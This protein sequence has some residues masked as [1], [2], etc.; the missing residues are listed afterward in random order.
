MKPNSAAA[1]RE[2]IATVQK[3]TLEIP[4]LE[5]T[6]ADNLKSLSTLEADGYL[7][8]KVVIDEIVRRQAFAALF[9]R[10]IEA[11]QSTLI[12]AEQS[13][14]ESVDGFISGELRERVT[15]IAKSVRAKVRSALKFAF[16]DNRALDHAV[17]ESELVQQLRGV[18]WAVG[19]ESSPANVIAYANRKLDALVAAEELAKRAA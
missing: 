13:L 1:V 9:P 5:S 3:L 10:R 11:R 19:I 2:A 7:E 16:T 15:E 4:A 8:D 18:E 12:L 17:E 6:A 14:K